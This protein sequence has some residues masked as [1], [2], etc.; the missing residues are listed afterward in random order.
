MASISKSVGTYQSSQWGCTFTLE[1][2]EKSYN[3]VGNTS[4]VGYSWK[5]VYNQSLGFSGSTRN[6]AGNLYVY[7]NGSTVVNG[8]SIPLKTQSYSGTLEAS[9]SGSISVAHNSDGKKDVSFGMEMTRGGG[10]YASDPY[11]WQAFSSVWG[12]CPLTALD[13]SPATISDF[14]VNWVTPVRASIHFAVNYDVS[15]VQYEVG[16]NGV[17]HI[18]PKETRDFEISNL[19]PNHT[20]QVRIWVKRSYN[21]VETYSSE[22]SVTT[23]KPNKP[24]AGKVEVSNITPFGAVVDW[25]GFSFGQYATWGHYNVLIKPVGTQTSWINNGQSTRYIGTGLKPNTKYV[26]RVQLVDDYGSESDIID[27]EFTTLNDQAKVWTNQEGKTQL[28]KAWFNEKGI[29]QKVKKFHV[30]NNGKIEKNKVF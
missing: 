7:I 19:A 24:N 3:V 8:A 17:W 23:P 27:A 2:W 12:S 28:G 11:V 20:R 5:A 6:N 29:N 10:N 18:L 25:S 1:V 21:N 22:L 30:N 16:G 4:E 14:R 15:D 26:A 13:R 9:G